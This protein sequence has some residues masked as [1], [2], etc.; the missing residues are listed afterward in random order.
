MAIHIQDFAGKEQ[1]QS[2]LCNWAKGTG[3]E[4]MVQSVDGKTVYYADGE[5]REPGKADALDRRSQEFG[6]SSIQCELQCDGEKVAS[7]YLKEDKDGDRDRQEAALKLLCLTLEEFVKAES[8]V[9]RFEDFASRLSAGITET[10]SLVKEIRKSTNDLK[11]I[12][13]RQKILALNANIEAARAG[14]HGKGFGVV[15]DEVG[16]L[17]DSSSAVNEKISSVVKRIAEV[18]S[19]LSG[20]ELEEQA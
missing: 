18:V 14:E 6:S 16:R 8:S 2:I 13:S 4:A 10:Q 17:S 12:Q 1:F 19:S 7:L 15:A 9:G 11:S 5:E 20:E 3:L